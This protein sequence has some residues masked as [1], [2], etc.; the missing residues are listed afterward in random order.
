MTRNSR[1]EAV[2][3]HDIAAAWAG[4]SVDFALHT[5]GDDQFVAFYD[6]DG[7]VTAGQRRLGG[8][9]WTLARVTD[10]R[11][12]RWDHHNRLALAVD[13]EG[14]L[15]LVGDLH[16]DP[17]NYFRTTEPLDVT[18]FERVDAMVGSEEERMTYP[19]FLRGPDDELVFKYRDGMSGAGDWI[20]NVYEP[21]RGEWDRLLDEP[22]TR[23]GER[24]NAYPEGPVRGPEGRYHLVWCWRDNPAA[25]TNHD[26][27][28]VRSPDLQNWETSRGRPVALPVEFHGGELVDPVPPYGGLLNSRIRLGF[29][30]QDRVVVSYMKFDPDGDTQLYNARCESDGW[31]VYET[32]DWDHRFT[33]GGTGSLGVSLDFSGVTVEPNGGLTQSYDHPKYGTGR[34]VLDEERLEPV[35]WRSPWHRYPDLGEPDDPQLRVNWVADGGDPEETFALRWVARDPQHGGD[36]APE[37]TPAPTTLRLYRLAGE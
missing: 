33:F 4:Q 35:E 3:S 2:E 6:A 14:H 11:N 9:A 20:Y 26:L 31:A 5:R 1:F 17:L 16:V 12:D 29:D 23:G 30:T 24:A 21:E 22:L 36:A 19:S 25:Q 10:A 15:H 27:Y 34:W 18:T 8:T 32:S 7:A 37:E 28:Y 13:R